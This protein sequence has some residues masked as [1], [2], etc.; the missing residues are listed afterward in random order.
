MLSYCTARELQAER[1]Y[2]VTEGTDLCRIT[3]PYLY[4]Y[5]KHAN[6]QMQTYP[7]FVSSTK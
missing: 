1:K 7:T 3:L 4:N 5:S 2:F 6:K